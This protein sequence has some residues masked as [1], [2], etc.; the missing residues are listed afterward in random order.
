MPS[1]Q[2]VVDGIAG[3]CTAGGDVYFAVD[4]GEVCIDG[5]RTDDKFFGYLAVC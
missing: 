3:G 4:R 1:D 2:S 5:S